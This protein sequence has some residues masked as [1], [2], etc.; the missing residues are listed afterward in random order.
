MQNEIGAEAFREWQRMPLDKP[1]N[2]STCEEL[3]L[4][5][6]HRYFVF[7]MGEVIETKYCVCD[8]CFEL[9]GKTEDD[10]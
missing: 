10:G 4:Q 7:I 5:F 9:K 3:M 2:C 1:I 6:G 8:S